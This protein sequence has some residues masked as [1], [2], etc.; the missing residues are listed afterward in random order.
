MCQ[1]GSVV[2]TQVYMKVDRRNESG[3]K[4]HEHARWGLS[5]EG[6]GGGGGGKEGT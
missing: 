4:K 6:G 3:I 1:G 5:N 2:H